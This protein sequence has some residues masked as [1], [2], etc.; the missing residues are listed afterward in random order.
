MHYSLRNR[1]HLYGSYSMKGT[2]KGE[3]ENISFGEL[4]NSLLICSRVVFM[5]YCLS[6]QESMVPNCGFVDVSGL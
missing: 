5:S 3:Y 1:G 2:S 4:K 6:T